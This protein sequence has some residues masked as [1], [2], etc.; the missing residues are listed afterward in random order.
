MMDYA[1]K[2]DAM[3]KVVL[4][5]MAK[6]KLATRAEAYP[7]VLGMATIVLDEE[8]YSLMLETLTK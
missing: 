8:D 3:D 7:Y 6:Y 2:S 5:L 4:T 1:E